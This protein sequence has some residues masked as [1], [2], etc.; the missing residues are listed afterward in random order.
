MEILTPEATNS[1]NPAIAV[2]PSGDFIITWVRRGTAQVNGV[3]RLAPEIVSKYRAAGSST[4]GNTQVIDQAFPVNEFVDG[5]IFQPSI[6][7][8]RQGNALVAYALTTAE[9]SSDHQAQSIYAAQR[10]PGAGVLWGPRAQVASR[11]TSNTV[12]EPSPALHDGN[13]LVS[14]TLDKSAGAVQVEA[15]YRAAGQ[16]AFGPKTILYPSPNG[17]DN[18]G[19]S[20]L[21]LRP[22]RKRARD[23]GDLPKQQG[24]G[25]VGVPARRRVQQ[26]RG[27]RAG[28]APGRQRQGGRDEDGRRRRSD[29]GLAGGRAVE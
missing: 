28:V 29:R 5:N 19:G 13:A 16:T 14:Y 10:P 11:G 12:R 1:T 8:D 4:W 20:Q 7:M 3:P 24:S 2:D 25:H 6:V 23:V 15:V 18:A 22:G 21:S 27:E 17:G 26:L 9:I